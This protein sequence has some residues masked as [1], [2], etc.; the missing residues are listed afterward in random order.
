MLVRVR[1]P[2]GEIVVWLLERINRNVITVPNIDHVDCDVRRINH[3]LNAIWTRYEN[4][5][6]RR[7]PRIRSPRRHDG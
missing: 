1:Y 3:E 7:S 5:P 4:Q 2:V 6:W